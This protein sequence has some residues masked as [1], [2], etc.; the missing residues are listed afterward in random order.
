[1]RWRTAAA[2]ST[3]AADSAARSPRSPSAT[4]AAAWPGS[5]STSGSS[6]GPA[7]RGGAGRRVPVAPASLDH[8]LAVECVFHFPSRKGFFRE[9]ARV[10]RPG[11]TLALSDF[12]LAP[13]G[14]PTFLAQVA[15]LGPGDWYG[16]SA[17]PVT[18]A[19]YE[20]AGRAMG[21]GVLEDDDVT[22]RALPTYAARRRL[23]QEMGSPEGVATIDR[24]ER[25]AL[26]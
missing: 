5:T 20:R 18:S 8:V 1:R 11:G 22:A 9:A 10:L 26:R 14:M 6:A 17:A 4:A 21:D 25:L 23:Y 24:V 12:L 16:H 19:A 13:G 7:G 3:W 15:E 2:S